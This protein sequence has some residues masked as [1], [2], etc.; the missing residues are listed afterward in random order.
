MSPAF[1]AFCSGHRRATRFLPLAALLFALAVLGP[2]ATASNYSCGN[3]NT[4]HCYGQTA[5]QEQP[6]YFGSYVDL[7]QVAMNCASGCGGFLNNEMWLIDYQTPACVNNAYQAC[8]VEAGFHALDGGGN[9]IYFWADS[10]PLSSNTYNNHFLSQADFADFEHF[11]IIKDSRNGARGVF[12]VW[13]YNDSKSVFFNGTSTN[14]NMSANAIHIGSELAGTN[15]ASASQALFQRN[16]WAVKPLGSDFTFW[17]NRQIDA[18]TVRS[19]GPPNGSWL[20]NPT[21]PP[22]PEGGMFTT[23]CCN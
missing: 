23:N 16:I 15:G 6:Q 21:T 22:P 1:A 10:R 20:I 9:P 8:W 19:D 5:W 18:G 4:G 2:P 17:Y 12:Q 3:P 7:L 11:M 14:N 13:I